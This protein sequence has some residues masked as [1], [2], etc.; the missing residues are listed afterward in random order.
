MGAGESAR[1]PV[2]A[3]RRL[4]RSTLGVSA[5]SDFMYLGHRVDDVY[6]YVKDLLGMN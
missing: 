2:S 4:V 3:Q 1:V 6:L 5:C